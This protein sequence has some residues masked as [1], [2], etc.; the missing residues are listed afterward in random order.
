[1]AKGQREK[2]FQCGFAPE[3]RKAGQGNSNSRKKWC[4]SVA[5][6]PAFCAQ[7]ELSEGQEVGLSF[8]TGQLEE[9][10]ARDIQPEGDLA[11]GQ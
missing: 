9:K 3:A 7:R 1:M 2:S 5:L 8:Q 4:W 6:M 11:Q 10:E